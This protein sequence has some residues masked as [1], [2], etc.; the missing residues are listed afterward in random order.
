MI[1]ILL[2]MISVSIKSFILSVSVSNYWKCAIFNWLSCLIDFISIFFIISFVFYVPS[3]SSENEINPFAVIQEIWIYCI[4]IGVVPFALF[5]SIAINVSTIFYY[6][7]KCNCGYIVVFLFIQIAW[8]IG[9]CFAIM[10][11][12][13]TCFIIFASIFAFNGLSTRIG[14]NSDFYLPLISFIKNAKK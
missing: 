2:S 7:P 6:Y 11:L 1:S 14:T 9:L 12:S 8:I 4:L 13:I 10:S 3:D 5:G